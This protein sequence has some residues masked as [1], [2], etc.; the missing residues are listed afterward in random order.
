LPL[1]IGPTIDST[2]PLSRRSIALRP[3]VDSAQRNDRRIIEII[4]FSKQK[5]S[6]RA[7]QVVLPHFFK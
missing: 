3:S 1:N 2:W 4:F 7:F 5:A 6:A